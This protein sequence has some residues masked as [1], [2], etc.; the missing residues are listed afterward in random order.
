[1]SEGKQAV[2]WALIFNT[3][4]KETLRSM[5]FNAASEFRGSN[6]DRRMVYEISRSD[7]E[8]T[9]LEITDHVDVLEEDL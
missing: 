3:F 2:E 6:Q 4:G 5:L 8:Y 7:D 1:M 9:A